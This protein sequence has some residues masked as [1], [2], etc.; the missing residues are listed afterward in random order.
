[1]DAYQEAL[2]LCAYTRQKYEQTSWVVW[3]SFHSKAV[4][5]A[6]GTLYQLA[7]KEQGDG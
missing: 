1:M 7:L 4:E 2:D 5:L 6:A 3:R